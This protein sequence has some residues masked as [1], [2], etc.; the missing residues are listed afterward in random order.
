MIPRNLL[1]ENWTKERVIKKKLIKILEPHGLKGLGESHCDNCDKVMLPN[2]MG[3]Q[4]KENLDAWFC[5]I[6]CLESYGNYYNY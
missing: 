5:S 2:T 1:M 4:D 3:F 6:S